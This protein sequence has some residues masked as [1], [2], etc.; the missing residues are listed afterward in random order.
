M[1]R[2][3]CCLLYLAI[4]NPTLRPKHPIDDD[5]E[6][7]EEQ[8]HILFYTSKE[9]AVSRDRMLRQIGLSKALVNFTELFNPNDKCET[10]HSQ[11]RRIILVSPEPNFWINACVEL[12][13]TLQVPA[14]SKNAGKSK[15]KTAAKE[16]EK[17]AQPPVY[18]YED[19]TVH[20]IAIRSQLLHAYERFKLMHGSFTSILAELGQEAL[21]LQLERF[22]TVWAWSWNL[23][24]KAQIA[25]Q[26][27]LSLQPYYSAL[28]PLLDRYSANLPEHVAPVVLSQTHII[29]STRYISGE[30]PAVLVERL[31]SMVPPPA[32][33]TEDPLARSVDTIQPDPPDSDPGESKGNSTGI[34]GLPAVNV[35]MDVR[36][37]NWNP[38]GKGGSK[39]AEESA[40]DEQK[41][42]NATVPDQPP[43][44][45]IEQ[46][47]QPD[48]A[49]QEATE[50]QVDSK[51]LEEALASEGLSSTAQPE[52]EEPKEE[53]QAS[54]KQEPSEV[55]TLRIDTD[56]SRLTREHSL[57]V[58]QEN[59]HL[60]IDD[61]TAS[62]Q[63]SKTIL[64]RARFPSSSSR[65][66]TPAPPEFSRCLLYL[67]SSDDLV[68]TRKRPVF[69]YTRNGT[70]LALL[71][72]EDEES[73]SSELDE[74]L[75]AAAQQATELMDEIELTIQNAALSK[76]SESLPTA[77]KI[78]QSPD[79][80][81]ISTDHYLLQSP[82]FA[83]DS[84]HL[85][86]SVALFEK[87]EFTFFPPYLKRKSNAI[88]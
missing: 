46:G 2:I 5:D 59:R 67:P 72:L 56:S 74:I 69:Y 65:S 1:S 68:V 16:K 31:M 12:P 44:D 42:T 83:S 10:I 58:D 37:W 23:E 77:S 40:Q 41:E 47:E 27:G 85:H 80:Y 36:K 87:F 66:S 73:A 43:R 6:D 52:A 88:L 51:S 54:R 8:A 55:D 82:G 21:E 17:E 29:P 49:H 22:F 86:N 61:G 81:A 57:S 20:D 33:P 18:D 15:S 78:L 64:P 63:S 75:S 35:N 28:I 11:S 71:G 60:H 32:A 50:V 76:L 7:A 70:M 9:R 14:P 13:K 48:S 79:Q 4:Y 45:D 53:D 3:P 30:Y 24:A 84:C 25:D 39:S 38:F 26:L 19:G 34:F 62:P